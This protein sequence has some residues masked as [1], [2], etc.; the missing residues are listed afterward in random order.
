MI[1]RRLT[2]NNVVKPDA[3]VMS[4]IA[5]GQPVVLTNTPRVPRT[6]RLSCAQMVRGL[7]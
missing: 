1:A 5:A 2:T 4:V 7:I 3:T 6:S